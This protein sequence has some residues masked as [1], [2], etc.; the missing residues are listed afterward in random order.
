MRDRLGLRPTPNHMGMREVSIP[1]R[2]P[3]NWRWQ[4]LS[5]FSTLFFQVRF[6]IAM[7]CPKKSCSCNFP[8]DVSTICPNPSCIE[9][10]RTII[11][12]MM[13]CIHH[14]VLAKQWLA[15][16]TGPHL[17]ATSLQLLVQDTKTISLA[18]GRIETTIGV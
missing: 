7:V 18:G 9:L 13:S 8:H 1:P 17:G 3:K 14:K 12:I 2:I 5:S 6:R 15:T 4:K 16:F 11:N 10:R